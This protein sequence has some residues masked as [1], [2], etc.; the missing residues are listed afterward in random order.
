[1][2]KYEKK[3]FEACQHQ[4]LHT[5]FTYIQT[6]DLSNEPFITMLSSSFKNKNL[7]ILSKHTIIYS[8][9]PILSIP[10]TNKK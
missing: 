3:Y 8:V 2:N 6:K 9:P 4:I 10:L 5:I 1:M 7:N